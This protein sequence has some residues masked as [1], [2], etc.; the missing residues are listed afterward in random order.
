M[1]GLD[2]SVKQPAKVL[3]ILVM[4]IGKQ[5]KNNG[6]DVISF[7]QF[8]NDDMTSYGGILSKSGPVFFYW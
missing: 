3:I 8:L 4:I 6:M 2:L 7:N 1:V 5:I